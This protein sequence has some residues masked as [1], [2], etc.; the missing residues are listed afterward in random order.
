MN[1]LSIPF[2]FLDIKCYC[3]VT[4]GLPLLFR[5]IPETLG[6]D[7]CQVKCVLMLVTEI[8]SIFYISRSPDEKKNK[9]HCRSSD[10]EL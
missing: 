5:I 6:L 1:E 4:V 3:V 2:R 8:K 7:A 10:Q 9:D